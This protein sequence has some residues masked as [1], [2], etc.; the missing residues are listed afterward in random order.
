MQEEQDVDISQLPEEELKQLLMA[1]ISQAFEAKGL[2]LAAFQTQFRDLFETSPEPLFHAT[3]PTTLKVGQFNGPLTEIS[4]SDFE[5][6]ETITWST[7]PL[8][9]QDI[10]PLL[11]ENH[12]F[13]MGFNAAVAEIFCRTFPNYAICE[14]ND[15][16]GK[17]LVFVPSATTPMLPAGAVVG[18]YT[19]ILSSA[20]T[21]KGFCPYGYSVKS[22][23]DANHP[24]IFDALR[25]GNEFFDAEKFR[26]F[27][28][29]AQHAPDEE[30]LSNIKNL[31][32]DIK[33][34]VVRANI[35]AAPTLHCGID[36]LM[37]YTS[38][39]IKP[40]PGKTAL[41]LV[42]YGSYFNG[43]PYQL[44]D[45]HGNVIGIVN[46]NNE[47]ERNPHYSPG[48]KPPK[49]PKTLSSAQLQQ[50]AQK[51]ALP[52]QDSL[53]MYL[54]QQMKFVIKLY[55]KR[56]TANTERL[57]DAFIAVFSRTTQ[58]SALHDAIDRAV[59]IDK[60]LDPY[61]ELAPLKNELIL[62]LKMH[63]SY[64]VLLGT[65]KTHLQEDSKT[66]PAKW[67]NKT[68]KWQIYGVEEKLCLGFFG[69]TTDLRRAKK[70]LSYLNP[71]I[72]HFGDKELLAIAVSVMFE[73]E[74]TAKKQPEKSARTGNKK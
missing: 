2:S 43:K 31:P 51:H 61:P 18:I 65:Y 53:A 56:A 62:L 16:A 59:T 37:Y 29:Y 17:A 24:A 6:Q 66:C 5:A 42:D 50:I 10:R 73:R 26:N 67:V 9:A 19:G 22:F 8:I 21:G 35:V 60:Q 33:P 15:T 12:N 74:G 52:A 44:F 69:R 63:N 11:Y 27:T 3:K 32:D 23:N 46:E 64:L 40:E 49:T 68:E 1:S 55:R 72:T 70:E 13:P 57:L 36:V 48:K 47:F 38:H 39:D 41:L 54:F 30:R 58:G 34:Y 14:L 7:S 4:L 28:S 25:F 71:F 45:H 20:S